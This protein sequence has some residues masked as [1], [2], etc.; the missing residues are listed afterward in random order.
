MSKDGADICIENSNLDML[1]SYDEET[2]IITNGSFY[3][4]G[5]RQ[6]DSASL[7]EYDVLVFEEGLSIVILN[8]SLALASN[9]NVSTNLIVFEQDEQEDRAKEFHRHQGLFFENRRIE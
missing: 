3:L 1:I 8:K 4:N 2:K 6:K 5:E 7:K 9:F